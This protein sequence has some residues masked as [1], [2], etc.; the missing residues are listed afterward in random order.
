VGPKVDAQRRG[1]AVRVTAALDRRDEAS[2]I[3]IRLTIDVLDRVE[4]ITVEQFRVELREC[5]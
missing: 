1:R 4:E 2:R 5:V 3:V